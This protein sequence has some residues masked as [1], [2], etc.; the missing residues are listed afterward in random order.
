MSTARTCGLDQQWL[1]IYLNGDLTSAE[2]RI[3][4][5]HLQRCADC[6]QELA[7]QEGR[8]I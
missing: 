8:V 2:G 1:H 7:R 3:F 5:T 6:R 4:E